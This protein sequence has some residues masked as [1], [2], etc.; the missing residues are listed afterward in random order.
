MPAPECRTTADRYD[1]ART[2]YNSLKNG[3][4]MRTKTSQ[5]MNNVY[6]A[7]F[8]CR[9]LLVSVPVLLVFPADSFAQTGETVYATYCAGCHGAQLQGSVAPPLIKKDWKHGSDRNSILNTIRN[10]VPQTEMMKWEG[11]LSAR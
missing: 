8:V 3:I 2:A 1:P 9:L 11:V 6:R 4:G 7:A 10:G 5:V